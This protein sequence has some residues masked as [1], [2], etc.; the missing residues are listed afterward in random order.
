MRTLVRVLEATLRLAHPLIPFIT[1]ELWQKVAPLA[2]KAG[3]SIMIAP[4]PQAEPGKIDAAAEEEVARLKAL[5]DACRNL[6][7][8]M[9]VAPG[10]RIPLYAEGASAEIDQFFPYM[11]VLARLSETHRVAEL[12][13]ADAP[14]AIAGE[15]RLML[16]IEIDVAAEI[17]RLEKE[18]SRVAAEI[19][20]A[21]A[22]LANP[23]F[24]ERAPPAVVA[25][26]RERLASQEATLAKLDNQLSRL[27]PQ[28]TT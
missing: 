12:P 7:G 6:R 24:V 1:E 14:V 13:A 16:K 27:R 22:K 5:T 10:E 28:L 4:Y 9:N 2:G 17:A 26:E 25:Q 8:E 19:G 21:Q 11:R 3:D 18:R 20:K 23:S 15:T